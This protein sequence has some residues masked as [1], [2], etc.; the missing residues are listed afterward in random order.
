[1]T[2]GDLKWNNRVGQGRNERGQ[3]GIGRRTQS[4][5]EFPPIEQEKPSKSSA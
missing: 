1:M 3:K 2:A 4:K 5:A